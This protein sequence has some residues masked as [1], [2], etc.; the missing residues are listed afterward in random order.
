MKFISTPDG[1]VQERP[2]EQPQCRFGDGDAAALFGL[3]AG[4]YCFHDDVKQALCV[5]HI[6]RANPL[7]N[8]WL[9]ESYIML[10]GLAELGWVFDETAP[11]APT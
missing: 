7:G 9:I 11:G 6:I 3:D 5:Q 10:P 4:C 2:G 8:M 1:L